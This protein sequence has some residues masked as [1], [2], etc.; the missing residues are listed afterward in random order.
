MNIIYMIPIYAQSV[1]NGTRT[2]EQLPLNIQEAVRAEINKKQYSN[3][4]LHIVD[5][6]QEEE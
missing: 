1:L 5:L 3:A 4:I 6:S 2:I